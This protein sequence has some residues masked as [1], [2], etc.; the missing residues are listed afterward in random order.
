LLSRCAGFLTAV[1]NLYQYDVISNAPAV[2]ARCRF[3]G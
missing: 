1:K 2:L 3:D